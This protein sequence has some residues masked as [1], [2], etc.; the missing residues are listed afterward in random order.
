MEFNFPVVMSPV[1]LVPRAL[2]TIQVQRQFMNVKP[3][4]LV[5]TGPTASDQARA[6]YRIPVVKRDYDLKTT[7]LGPPIIFQTRTQ[8]S[9]R[10]PA[11]EPREYTS[12]YLHEVHGKAMKER[13]AEP[14]NCDTETLQNQESVLSC[15]GNDLTGNDHVWHKCI[16]VCVTCGAPRVHAESIPHQNEYRCKRHAIWTS[17]HTGR[18]CSCYI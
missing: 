11:S 17:A 1:Y 15:R 8:A 12:K 10:C 16:C 3:E 18:A 9:K 4:M 6:S 2:E 13:C 7:L 5:R 14:F